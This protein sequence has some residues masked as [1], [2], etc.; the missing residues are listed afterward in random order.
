MKPVFRIAEEIEREIQTS[1]DYS[2]THV[3][4]HQI[5]LLYGKGWRWKDVARLRGRRD[6]GRCR[7]TRV[8]GEH[9]SGVES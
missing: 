4:L 6:V 8:A 1:I 5:Y 2:R 3:A 9:G 7:E